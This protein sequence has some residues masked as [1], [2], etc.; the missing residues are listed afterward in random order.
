MIAPGDLTAN[1]GV[2]GPYFSA[3]PKFSILDCGEFSLV[4]YYLKEYLKDE[5]T[6]PVAVLDMIHRKN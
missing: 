4:Y 6:L 2:G 5:S 1:L 3:N